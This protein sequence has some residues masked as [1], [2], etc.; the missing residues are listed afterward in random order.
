[1][2]RRSLSEDKERL[3]EEPDIM[4]AVAGDERMPPPER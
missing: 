3:F 2:L 1:V 4:F